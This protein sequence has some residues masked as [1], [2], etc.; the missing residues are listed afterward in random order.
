MVPRAVGQGWTPRTLSVWPPPTAVAPRVASRDG[1]V[2]DGLH[3]PVVTTVVPVDPDQPD[4]RE[5]AGAG[6]AL[7]QGRLVAFPTETVYGLGAHA[8]DADAV[9]GVFAAKARPAGNPLIVHVTGLA[10]AAEVA[11]L[12]PLAERL[13]ARFWPGPLT[14][15]LAARP[16]VPEITR[17]GLSTVAVRAPAHPVAHA[18]LTAAGVPVAAPSANASG[19]PSPT[20]AA[21]VLADLD[22]RIDMVV[23]GGPCRF[24]VES[25]VVDARGEA[26]SVLRE[27]VVTREQL[28]E[29][30]A[31]GEAH[32]SPGSRFRHYAPRCEV[33]IAPAGDAPARAAQLA[34]QGHAVGLVAP[35]PA[36][37]GVRTLATPGD[38]AA[39]GAVLYQ[40][41]REAETGELDVVVVA[42]V[43]ERG[44]GRA[45]MDRLRRAAAG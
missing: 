39:L 18:L 23:D 11:E 13:A 17:G 7:R 30:T 36:P 33:V 41:L 28:P 32:R 9:A 27:G 44:V 14:L 22:G 10:D 4:A 43:A 45:V 35:Q 6:A 12:T 8:L 37:A 5:L 15:V 40:A 20:T 1:P 34:G 2:P 3:S 26:P 42:A 16:P 19:R 38:A 25:T 21:H 24:G 31:D 29:V